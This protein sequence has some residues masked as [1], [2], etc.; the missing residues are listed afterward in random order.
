MA[1][2]D[3][4][5]VR[6]QALDKEIAGAVNGSGQ[7]FVPVVRGPG[8]K[9]LGIYNSDVNSTQSG[10]NFNIQCPSKTLLSPFA[11]VEYK[12]TLVLNGNIRNNAGVG[13][14][15]FLT[16]NNDSLKAFPLHRITSN[17][18]VNVNG[19]QVMS[20]RV[21]DLM[22]YLEKC[23]RDADDY[24]IDNAPW[25]PD[26]LGAY[27]ANDT[28]LWNVKGGMSSSG[29]E[30]PFRG[31]F[32]ITSWTQN[33][34]AQ[35]A[36]ATCTVVFTAREPVLCEPFNFM[37]GSSA[38]PGVNTLMIQY[39]LD[40]SSAQRM[41]AHGGTQVATQNVITS[42]S[43]TF[44]EIKLYLQHITPSNLDVIDNSWSKLMVYPFYQPPTELKNVTAAGA[45]AAPVVQATATEI[46]LTTSLLQL[47]QIPSRLIFWAGP[48][49]TEDALASTPAAFY[50][51]KDIKVT[52]NGMQPMFTNYTRQQLYRLSKKNG[53][54]RS[55]TEWSG[56]GYDNGGNTVVPRFVPTAGGPVIIDFAT[57]LVLPE[58][59]TVG[60]NY[61]CQITIEVTALNYLTVAQ[62]P[63]VTAPDVNQASLFTVV[64][65][66]QML[67]IQ[68]DQGASSVLISQSIVD[69][70]DVLDASKKPA[71]AIATAS[72]V[73][74]A[75][76]EDPMPFAGGSFWNTAKSLW[77]S[78]KPLLKLANKGLSAAD[79]AG[80][81]GSGAAHSGGVA[82]VAGQDQFSGAAAMS[83][84]ALR[85]RVR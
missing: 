80:L 18:V 78:A 20:Y 85:K 62:L 27:P 37:K 67:T 30:H 1:N 6:I 26:V 45:P 44:S 25:Y 35:G 82:M 50:P 2:Y 56:E 77:S 76:G 70:L 71:D 4:K 5:N 61:P 49:T 46:K 13:N 58:N 36:A 39:Q 34:A 3:S 15:D 11:V 41:W 40:Q 75:T 43:A 16:A 74:Q 7:A 66:P 24:G 8:Q 29:P 22:N 10:F 53:Y 81:L 84:A 65:M 38:I 59:V 79:S 28:T 48:K 42:A 32:S 17:L 60:M 14:H 47:S 64:E 83:G 51:I 21:K 33:Q 9:V 69:P 63:T 57:D 72:A 68:R 31:N 73:E 54:L 52:L 55:W 12:C 23:I 19:S